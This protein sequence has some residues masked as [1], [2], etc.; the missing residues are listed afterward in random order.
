MEPTA[1][2]VE[3]RNDDQ[4]TAVTHA[5]YI[6]DT[7]CIVRKHDEFAFGHYRTKEMVLAYYNALAAGDT[8]AVVEV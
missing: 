6:L 3:G 4:E 8:D 2:P 7:F 1:K 5:A